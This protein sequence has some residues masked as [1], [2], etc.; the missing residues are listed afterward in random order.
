MHVALHAGSVPAVFRQGTPLHPL[1][2]LCWRVCP[3]LLPVMVCLWTAAVS[4]REEMCLGPLKNMKALWFASRKKY[5]RTQGQPGTSSAQ[6]P[7]TAKGVHTH[8]ASHNLLCTQ[9]TENQ[10]CGRREGDSSTIECEKKLRTDST[11]CNAQSCL[12]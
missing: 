6:S 7:Q 4:R 8:T 2:M 9:K 11:N 5:A 3:E 12:E 1:H 10:Q